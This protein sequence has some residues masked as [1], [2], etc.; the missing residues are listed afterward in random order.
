MLRPVLLIGLLG[1]FLVVRA[2][3]PAA[4]FSGQLSVEQKA[5][6]GLAGLTPEQLAALDAAV[7]AYARGER[8]LAVQEAE[9]RAAAERQQ[10]EKK[11]ADEAVA[12]YKRTQEP[13]VVA[14]TLERFKQKQAEERQER[15]VG[16][17]VGD[18]QGWR[19][20]T[21]FAFENGQIWRQTGTEVNELPTVRNAEVEIY[22]SGSGY[23]RLRYGDAWIT[24]KRVQ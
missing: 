6:L 18:F 3:E 12:A 8:S 4:S 20:G 16:R 9:R 21:Y 11:A 24:V 10:A 13:G 22:R 2:A 15:F 1:G 17:V 7:A 14:R 23:W 5:R 19:G